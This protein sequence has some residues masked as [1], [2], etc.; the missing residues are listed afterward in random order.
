MLQSALRLLGTML[1]DNKQL[2]G[3]LHVERL[4]VFALIW[5]FGAFLERLQDRKAF[6]QLLKSL[7]NWCAFHNQHVLLLIL[8]QLNITL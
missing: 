3:E 8:K 2:A 4:L 1:T 6:D 5:S 7:S